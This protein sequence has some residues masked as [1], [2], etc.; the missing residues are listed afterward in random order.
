L[1]KQ[2]K[3]RTRM[4]GAVVAVPGAIFPVFFGAAE[5]HEPC[6]SALM[7]RSKG[8]DIRDDGEVR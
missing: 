5:A 8:A 6:F 3:Q 2:I 4:L 1:S 7:R